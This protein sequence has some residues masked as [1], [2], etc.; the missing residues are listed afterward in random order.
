MPHKDYDYWIDANLPPQLA[1]WLKERFSVN[2]FSLKALQLLQSPD[3]EIYQLA[4][5]KKI[6]ILT[7]DEDFAELLRLKGPPPKVIW[8]TAG[9]ISNIDLKKIVIDCFEKAISSL[10]A[11][12]HLVEIANSI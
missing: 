11:G 4:S 12:N 1:E 3:K 2:A 8:I 5:E 7:K 6:I 9:N 10:D